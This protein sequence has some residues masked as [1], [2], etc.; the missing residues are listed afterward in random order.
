MMPS[1]PRFSDMP[2]RPA[3]TREESSP[4]GEGGPGVGDIPT[5]RSRSQGLR[6]AR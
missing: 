5:R 4:P 2:P 6:M 3:G 1:P